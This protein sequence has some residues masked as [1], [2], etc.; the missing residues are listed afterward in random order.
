MKKLSEVCKITG[1]SRR[2]LQGYDQMGLLSPTAK[3]EAGYWL[4][5]DEAIKKLIVIKIFTE[6][7]YTRE[8][9]KELLDAPVINLANE[10]DLL[11]SA[12]R[13][14]QRHIEGIIRTIRL[15]KI[16]SQ[17]S[18]SARTALQE[19]DSLVAYGQRDFSTCFGSLVSEASKLDSELDAHEMEMFMLFWY[20]LIVVGLVTQRND[21]DA[22]GNAISECFDHF[23]NMI[24]SFDKESEAEFEE[25]EY[26]E[27]FADFVSGLVS[28]DDTSHALE[29]MCGNGSKRR[30]VKAVHTWCKE[31]KETRNGQ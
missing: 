14:E 22:T 28:Q 29:E 6:A 26:R 9:V 21:E 30:I 2:A 15:F 5:D 19:I 17:L 4:Y 1:L 23:Q 27:M 10:Y 7:G 18:D 11:V 8:H 16:E 31:S 24:S 12:L 25:A 3:T 20:S 13:E